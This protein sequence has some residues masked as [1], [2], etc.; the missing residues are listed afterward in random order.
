[1]AIEFC[2]HCGKEM[3]VAEEAPWDGLCPGCTWRQSDGA[4][5][6]VVLAFALSA[7]LGVWLLHAASPSQ[8]APPQQQAVLQFDAGDLPPDTSSELALR[9]IQID[10]TDPEGLRSTAEVEPQ[11]A[12]D[13]GLV[14]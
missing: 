8:A 9:H 2:E 5:W 7:L 3:E 10:I 6:Q 4:E 11:E 12:F 14:D 1:M 13:P